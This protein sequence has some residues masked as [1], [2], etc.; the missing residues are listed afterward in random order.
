MTIQFLQKPTSTTCRKAKAFFEKVG[1]DLALRN[2]DAQRLT[3]DEQK[4][5]IGNRD[6]KKFL[7][8]R[9]EL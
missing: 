5:L 6:H 7:N 1:A 3:E 9:N 4:T 2:L 8:T